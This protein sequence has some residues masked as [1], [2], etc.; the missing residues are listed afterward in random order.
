M[1]GSFTKKIKKLRRW[2]VS[3]LV[4]V[5]SA[6][7]L[8]SCTD[9]YEFSWQSK[10]LYIIMPEPRY[11]FGVSG[12]GEES[13]DWHE[14]DPGELKEDIFQTLKKSNRSGDLDIYV[15]F[16]YKETDKYGNVSTK[17]KPAKYV[18][19]IQMSEVPK[20]KDSDYFGTNYKILD[21]IIAASMRY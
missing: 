1:H 12:L 21:S 5:V 17:R 10:G 8:G 3:L 7:V 14:V 13:I 19:T 4:F 9:P 20:Y 11:T 16:T 2:V 18:V 15:I 6:L